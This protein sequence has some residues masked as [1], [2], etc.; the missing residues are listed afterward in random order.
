MF[1]AASNA[2]KPPETLL[3]LGRLEGGHAFAPPVTGPNHYNLGR[4]FGHFNL[5]AR[6]IA[7]RKQ[8]A[9]R[10]RECREP[11]AEGKLGFHGVA[12]S[13]AGCP[14]RKIRMPGEEAT[15]LRRYRLHAGPSP[16]HGGLGVGLADLCPA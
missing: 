15:V 16:A 12:E 6:G 9:A 7:R 8:R 2:P 1:S 13:G 3:S 4:R 10:D 11:N 14:H 5:Y